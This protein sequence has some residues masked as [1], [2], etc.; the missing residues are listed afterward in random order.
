MKFEYND[1]LISQLK[2]EQL[3]IKN[4]K[5]KLEYFLYHYQYDKQDYNTYKILECLEDSLA[6]LKQYYNDIE[7]LLNINDNIKAQEYLKNIDVDK[8]FK[9]YMYIKNRNIKS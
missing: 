1:H 6:C 4:K 9:K 7:Q 8:V 5:D 3:K 2:K